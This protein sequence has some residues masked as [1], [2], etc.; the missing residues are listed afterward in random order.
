VSVC[1][2]CGS[3]PCVGRALVKVGPSVWAGPLCGAA[4]VRGGPLWVDPL[5]V[6]PL[7]CSRRSRAIYSR[8]VSRSCS[9]SRSGS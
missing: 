2:L 7:V 4:P 3:V 9:R 5:W 1:L 6:P 8:D